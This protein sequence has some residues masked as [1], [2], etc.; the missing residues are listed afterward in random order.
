MLFGKAGRDKSVF[1]LVFVLRMLLCARPGAATGGR[2][3]SIARTNVTQVLS[4][5][6]ALLSLTVSHAM[7]LATGHWPNEARLRVVGCGE[8]VFDQSSLHL[9]DDGFEPGRNNEL[10]GFGSKQPVATVV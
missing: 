6:T 3:T 10:R 1:L 8:L 7:S 2:C 4:V 5:G 9:D